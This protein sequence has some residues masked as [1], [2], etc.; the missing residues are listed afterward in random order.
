MQEEPS[1]IAGENLS[2]LEPV[3]TSFGRRSTAIFLIPKGVLH[4]FFCCRCAC[5]N[6]R[7]Q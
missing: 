3:C 7:G 1:V 6:Q 4:F 2:P 5:R